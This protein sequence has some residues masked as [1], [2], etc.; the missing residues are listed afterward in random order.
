MKIATKP[1]ISML[2]WDKTN[3]SPLKGIQ[4]PS[5]LPNLRMNPYWYSKKMTILYRMKKWIMT[6]RKMMTTRTLSGLRTFKSLPSLQSRDT[7]TVTSTPRM[8]RRKIRKH[9]YP[10]KMMITRMSM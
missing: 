8:S 3:Y 7:S 5:R 1:K 10:M 4:M 6:T 9:L 2:I